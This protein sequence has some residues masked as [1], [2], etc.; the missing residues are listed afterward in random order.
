MHVKER[1]NDYT[2]LETF[3]LSMGLFNPF[4]SSKV[5]QME[6][7]LF[8]FTP[9]E[10]RIQSFCAFIALSTKHIRVVTLTVFVTHK[11]Y[12]VHTH[13]FF[14]VTNG[15]GNHIFV[16]LTCRTSFTWHPTW[17]KNIFR[18]EGPWLSKVRGRGE[19]KFWLGLQ[20]FTNIGPYLSYASID[21]PPV[22]WFTSLECNKIG[23]SSIKLSKFVCQFLPL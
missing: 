15:I 16:F 11:Y 17:Q 4:W 3:S 10:E 21:R 6:F 12:I 14:L 1:G 2:F 18:P 13:I 23:T 8:K 5:Y 20:L 19:L 7:G 22:F 9:E